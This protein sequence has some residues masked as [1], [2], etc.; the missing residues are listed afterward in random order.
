MATLST[1][2]Q[3]KTNPKKKRFSTEEMSFIRRVS[4]V[5]SVIVQIQWKSETEG[6]HLTKVD[7]V[8]SAWIVF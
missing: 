3:D 5:A 4:V 7:F 1:T 2:Q 8:T 6:F